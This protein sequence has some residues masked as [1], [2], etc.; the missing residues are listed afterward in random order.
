MKNIKLSKVNI[1]HF[2]YEIQGIFIHFDDISWE[3]L[4]FENSP[5]SHFRYK[6]QGILIHLDEF[7]WKIL[8]FQSSP[9]SNFRYEL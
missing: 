1:F 8:I 2:S 4:N 7:S 6:I 5:I 9:I 3:I